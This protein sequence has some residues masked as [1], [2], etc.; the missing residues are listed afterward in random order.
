[1]MRNELTDGMKA[2]MKAGEKR[3]LGTLRLI[4]AAIKDRDIS[5]RGCGKERVGDD[6][7]LQILG[8]MI[9]QREESARIYEESNR[10]ELAAQEREEMEIIREYMPQQM[11]EEEV[12]AACKDVVGEVNG[13]S[14]RDMGKCMNALKARYPGQLDVGQASKV[15]KEL[16]G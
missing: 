7:I 2:A 12:R 16:L 8:K 14:L 11:C 10:L 9:K 4:N 6:E 1:M 15:V 13:E 5:N 3:K